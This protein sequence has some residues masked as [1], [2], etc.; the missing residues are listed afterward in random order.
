MVES[1]IGLCDWFR[2]DRQAARP[3]AASQ[4]YALVNNGCTRAEMNHTTGEV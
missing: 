4:S 3:A 1:L 2:V